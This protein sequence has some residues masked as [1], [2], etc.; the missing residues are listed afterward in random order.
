MRADRSAWSKSLQQSWSTRGLLAVA[1]LPA[2]ALF[3]LLSATRQWLFRRAWL[4]TCTLG[5]P[6][7]VV[8]NLL[9]GGAGK[10]P[11]VMAV[12]ELLRRRGFTPGIL[13]R[14]YAGSNSGTLEVQ[15]D[16]EAR[17]CGDEPK[18]MHLRTRA[19]VIV[20]RDRVAAGREL[21]RLHPEVNVLV[22]DDGLQHHRLGRDA[23]VIVFDER[24]AGNGWLLPAGPLRETLGR[25]CPA[26][27]VVLYNAAQPS[28]HWPGTTAH[29]ALAGIVELGGWWRGESASLENLEALR[30]RSFL[31]AAG[32]ANPDR[33]FGLLG[34][35]G[36]ICQTLPLPD[37]YPYSKLP[38]PDSEV[39][40]VVT[41]K[42]AVKIDPQRAGNTRVWVAA[43]DFRTSPE[44]DSALMSLLP[45][46]S[47]QG[48]HHG[49]ASA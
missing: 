16:T 29:R 28:T 14:G 33:F 40:V 10:T 47:A 34:Q 11:A 5:V 42:D 27:S 46:I 32:I 22:S 45:P 8:G 21:L 2:A 36:L 3:W 41:E 1:L 20:G 13:S 31:A 6:V 39:D 48:L 35:F 4:E 44:F 15:A 17:E 25:A 19:P 30:G 12:V 23:Q 49:S 9:V 7:V 38:W 24:G 37:H 26:R 43:L 18:L